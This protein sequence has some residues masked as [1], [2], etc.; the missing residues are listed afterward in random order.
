[1]SSVFQCRNQNSKQIQFDA[2]LAPYNSRK[3][4]LYQCINKLILEKTA[5]SRLVHSP[6]QGFILEH[7]GTQTA[8]THPKM[9]RIVV[10]STGIL[11][12]LKTPHNVS[13]HSCLVNAENELQ[14]KRH[15][16]ENFCILTM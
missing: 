2:I 4:S 12:W 10:K 11:P 6:R 13:L 8:P 15:L 14:L 1:M 3:C 16:M 7:S 9:L 5:C